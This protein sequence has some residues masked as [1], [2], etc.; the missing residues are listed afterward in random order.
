VTFTRN[1]VT[2][3][4]GIAPIRV[5]ILTNIT[6]V[7]FSAAWNDRVKGTIFGIP[8]HFISLEHLISNKRATGRATDLEQLKRLSSESTS[9]K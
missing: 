9:G 2:Y 4:I 6:G 3:Q 7:E 5:N 8:V 1:E